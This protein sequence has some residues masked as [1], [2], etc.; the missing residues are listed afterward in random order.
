M[1]ISKVQASKQYC[2]YI[3]HRKQSHQERI[4]KT[5]YYND[6]EQGIVESEQQLAAL[7]VQL[8]GDEFAIKG[9]EALTKK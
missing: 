7:I 6:I 5:W 9:L 3:Q 4:R 2:E 1:S 8:T